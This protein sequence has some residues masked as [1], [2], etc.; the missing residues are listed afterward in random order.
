MIHFSVGPEGKTQL[1]A[2][3]RKHDIPFYELR[4]DSKDLR[5]PDWFKVKSR[6]TEGK[7]KRSMNEFIDEVDVSLKEVAKLIIPELLK[8]SD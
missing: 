1:S 5:Q 8:V 4:G 7:V 2:F 6:V 3:F